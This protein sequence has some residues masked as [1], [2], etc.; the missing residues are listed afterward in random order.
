MIAKILERIDLL[1][2]KP[3][4]QL[5]REVNWEDYIGKLRNNDRYDVEEIC[6]RL[7]LLSK[8]KIFPLAIMA[9][10]SV[11]NKNG[12]YNDIDLAVFP[13]H[14]R[15][16]ER[17]EEILATFITNQPEVVKESG[18]NQ[19]E[20]KERKWWSFNMYDLCRYWELRFPKGKPIQL[21]ICTDWRKMTLRKKLEMEGNE[22]TFFNRNFAYL[23]LTQK[24]RATDLL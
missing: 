22:A 4:P 7:L 10:G 2:E 3:L 5:P 12:G 1:F 13:L 8:E 16:L 17:A 18:S 11:L 15:D 9:V 23:I 20:V 21:F 14:N 24:N 19:M 6:R